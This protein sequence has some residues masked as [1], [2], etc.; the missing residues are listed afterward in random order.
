[1]VW[2]PNGKLYLPVYC[3]LKTSPV[4]E[5]FKKRWPI[6]PFENRTQIVSRKW[7]F[8]YQTVRFSDGH[9]TTVRPDLST[10][11]RK[12]ILIW[13]ISIN[14]LF[15]YK[16]LAHDSNG[17]SIG[18]LYTEISIIIQMIILLYVQST[19]KIL[20]VRISIGHFL[21][22]LVSGFQMHLKPGPKFF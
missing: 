10:H 19:S 14:K 22:I 17:L 8:E 5:W 16:F 20:T 15:S 11:I 2:Y 4:F 1:M 7:P 12:C 21:D 13:V 6:L 18:K 9:C 3:G